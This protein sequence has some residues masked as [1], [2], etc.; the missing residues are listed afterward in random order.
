MGIYRYS[1]NFTHSRPGASTPKITNL[2]FR[3]PLYGGLFLRL[4]CRSSVD[5]YIGDLLLVFQRY[6]LTFMADEPIVV[7]QEHS[8]L[9]HHLTFVIGLVFHLF[10]FELQDEPD[11]S[12]NCENEKQHSEGD[13][14]IQHRFFTDSP[15]NGEDVIDLGKNNRTDDQ[16]E[17]TQKKR[18]LAK[19][20]QR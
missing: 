10:E 1:C 9:K 15:N 8:Q 13:E 11:K 4:D 7:G 20:T 17:E 6:D 14:D 18:R 2:I 16:K 19:K 12:E 5:L 3:E